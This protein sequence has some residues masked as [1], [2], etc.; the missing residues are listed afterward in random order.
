ML[1][2]TREGRWSLIREHNALGLQ[3]I[4]HEVAFH[5]WRQLFQC[6][7]T[8]PD[9]KPLENQEGTWPLFSLH[10][11]YFCQ[12]ICSMAP[13]PRTAPQAPRT[14]PGA[15]SFGFQDADLH[16]AHLY[17]NFKGYCFVGTTLFSLTD[18]QRPPFMGN[19]SCGR[20]RA[21]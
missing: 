18:T 1:E 17:P 4:Q 11:Q 3:N 19:A 6:L 21:V 5:Q 7:I 13:A 10:N 2:V 9:R 15:R 14:A 12:V 20:F 8:E 16:S